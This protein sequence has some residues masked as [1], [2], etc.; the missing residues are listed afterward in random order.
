M[1]FNAEQI[2]ELVNGEVSGN[3]NIEIK[4]LAKIED[5]KDLKIETVWNVGYRL[6][7]SNTI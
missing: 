7:N 6:T 2:A 1:K 3:S 5:A 4:S